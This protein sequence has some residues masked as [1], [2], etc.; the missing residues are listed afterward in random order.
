MLGFSEHCARRA[1][2]RGRGKRGDMGGPVLAKRDGE[3][4]AV[5]LIYGSIG[6]GIVI[7]I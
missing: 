7:V 3:S 5:Y 4:R 6:I 2:G 1:E